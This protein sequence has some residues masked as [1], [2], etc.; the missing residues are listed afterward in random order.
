MAWVR[1][2]AV[3]VA[4]TLLGSFL[5]GP[6][7]ALT[8]VSALA[9]AVW[10]LRR[11]GALEGGKRLS[12]PIAAASAGLLGGLA[13]I[14]TRVLVAN[15]SDNAY[16]WIALLGGLLA[17]PAV[18]FALAAVAPAESV[19]GGLARAG[20]A[21]VWCLGI[22]GALLLIAGAPLYLLSI[23]RDAPGVFTDNRVAVNHV[24]GSL[25]LVA[26]VWLVGYHWPRRSRG[27]GTG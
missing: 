7:M 4:G 22:P 13:F 15:P 2:L 24:L 8:V 12:R 27:E 9:G 11:S 1:W 21:L 26:V 16:L 10:L 6:S 23:P 14:F 17:A 5:L 3:I 25:A 19:R 18:P 20:I